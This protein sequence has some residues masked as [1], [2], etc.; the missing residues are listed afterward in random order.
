[1]ASSGGS[2][3]TSFSSFSLPNQQ[4]YMAP[5]FSDLLANN[6]NKEEDI[7]M[8]NNN[9]NNNNNRS[10]S[11]S[12]SWFF[13][14]ENNNSN[15][16]FPKF[17]AFSPAALPI[18]PSPLSPSSYLTFPPSLSPSVL[19]DSPVLFGNSNVSFSSLN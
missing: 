2:I 17:K 19:L 14:Q 8:N 10:S 9:N 11:T 18:S 12:L 1:M 5:S 16:E 13:Q 15:G 7:M 4:Q 3:N 6:N